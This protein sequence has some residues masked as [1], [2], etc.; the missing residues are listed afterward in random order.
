MRFVSPSSHFVPNITFGHPMVECLRR[1]LG[2]DPFFGETEAVTYNESFVVWQ[3]CSCLKCFFVADMHMMVSRPEQWVKPMAAAGANQ[4]TFHLEATSNPGS[5]IKDIKESGMKV[6]ELWNR[7]FCFQPVGSCEC[8]LAR[9]AGVSAGRLGHQTWHHRW[10]TCTLGKPHWHGPG[11]DCGTW[12]WRTKVSGGHDAQGND[13]KL[14]AATRV[15]GSEPNQQ[16]CWQIASLFAT[17][18][19]FFCKAA[20]GVATAFIFTDAITQFLLYFDSVF[21][22]CNGI[23]G[24]ETRG[25]VRVCLASI[26]Y[27]ISGILFSNDIGLGAG[28]F[29]FC[30]Q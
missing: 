19:Q 30:P 26:Q 11:H 22:F 5:L 7:C 18:W 28:F 9:C 2:Q 6:T 1:C 17:A 20:T 10:R 14:R 4:Y 16:Q 12:L 25:S 8:T 15:V 13:G 24:E 21:F 27:Y 29:C 23:K 3:A